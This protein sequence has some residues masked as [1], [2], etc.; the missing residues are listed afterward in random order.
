[1]AWEKLADVDSPASATSLD[2]GTFTALKY[3]VYFVRVVGN[4]GAGS[5][6][7]NFNSITSSTHSWRYHE[8]GGSDT[9]ST[10]DAS[11]RIGE[12]GNRDC[13]VRG[14]ITNIDGNKKIGMGSATRAMVAGAANAPQR[15]ESFFKADMTS[16]ITSIQY[17]NDAGAAMGTATNLTVFGSD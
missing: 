8:D 1:M 6:V 16:Q 7:I 15:A 10:G 2:T 11:M 3:L 17:T 5:N 4:T 14:W 12:E 13:F 9:T